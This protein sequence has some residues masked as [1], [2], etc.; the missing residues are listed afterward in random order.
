M[1]KIIEVLP[2]PEGADGGAEYIAVRNTS[3]QSIIVDGWSIQNG[4]GKRIPLSGSFEP[5]ASK[6]VFTGSVALKNSGDALTLFD[7]AGRK[8]DFFS[9]GVAG[10]GQILQPAAFLTPELRQELFEGLAVDPAEV[11]VAPVQ[12]ISFPALFTGVLLGVV[13]AILAVWVLK[14]VRYDDVLKNPFATK[15]QPSL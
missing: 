3:N 8:Q 13:F 11:P 12:S 7:A 6:Q 9:Y 15:D 1:L 10:S 4:S 5:G 2:N 14:Q